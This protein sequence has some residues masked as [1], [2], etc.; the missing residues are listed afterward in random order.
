M[1]PFAWRRAIEVG[2][3]LFISGQTALDDE[4]QLVGIGNFDIQAEKTF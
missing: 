2:D 3:L 1:P 4:G